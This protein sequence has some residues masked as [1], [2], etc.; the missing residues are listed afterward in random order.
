MIGLKKAKHLK[1]R[2][3]VFF[4]M[5]SHYAR[6]AVFILLTAM[7]KGEG[8]VLVPSFQLIKLFSLVWLR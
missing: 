2:I 6:L 1:M 7:S 5:L 3:G 4:R 8:D